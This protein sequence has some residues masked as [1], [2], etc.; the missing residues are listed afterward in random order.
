M[1]TNGK[2]FLQMK[3][4]MQI[5][6]DEA[7]AYGVVFNASILSGEFSEKVQNLL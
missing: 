4:F 7:L 5:S 3:D 2:S 1:V 6:I